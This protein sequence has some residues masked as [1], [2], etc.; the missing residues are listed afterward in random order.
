LGTS[1]APPL[2]LSD[3]NGSGQLVNYRVKQNYY[4]VDRLFDRAELRLGD[5]VVGI[6]NSG[7]SSWSRWFSNRSKGLSENSRGCTLCR[8]SD[9]HGDNDH[10]RS[11]HA[12]SEHTGM[13]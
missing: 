10:N 12:S 13:H 1:E 8:D 4:V 2:F 3:E 7:S 11:D 5:T 9:D 6:S